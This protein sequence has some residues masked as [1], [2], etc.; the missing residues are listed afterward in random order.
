MAAR[1]LCILY[2][3]EEAKR[4]DELE[5][6][7]QSRR[8]RNLRQISSHRDYVLNFRLTRDLISALEGDLVPLLPPRVRRGGLSHHIKILCTLS[9][10]A[11][12]SYQN[13]VGKSLFNYVS[14]PS[15]SRA[16]RL[17]VNALNHPNIVKKYIRFPQ[18]LNEREIKKQGFYNKFKMPGVIG[19]V[20]GTLVAMVRPKTNEDRYYCRKGYHARNVLIINDCDLNILHVDATFG[21]ATHDSFIFNNTV[22][23]HHLEQIN[24]AGETAYLLGDS[25]YG[26]RSYLMTP[27]ANP[28]PGSPEEYYNTVHSTARNSVER[29]I[30]I[31]K[32]RF[33]CLLVHRVLHYD[34]EMVSKIVIAC[35]VLHNICNRAG[36][37]AFE[38]PYNLQHEEIR[39]Q[40]ESH[41]VEPAA[42]VGALEHGRACRRQLINILWRG[43]R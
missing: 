23:Q 22:I 7:R 17:I 39:L 15:A 35:C 3:L 25:A 14:Q 1:V 38:L 21:G 19:C 18:N 5:K 43:R 10:L 41:H 33:R 8:I 40:S 12:G 9:F 30:G 34:P 26:Q 2:L 36:L 13:I 32:G 4:R 20:D 6:R 37:P 27:C 42:S 31:L 24:N 29:T 16:I 11:T 28:E